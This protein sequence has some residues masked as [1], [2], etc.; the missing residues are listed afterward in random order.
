MQW[1]IPVIP[2]FERLRKEDPKFDPAWA[3][4]RETLSNRKTAI[5]INLIII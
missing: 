1:Y 3:I 5:K 2:A 4:E